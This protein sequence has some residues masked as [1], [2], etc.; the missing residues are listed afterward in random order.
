MLASRPPLGWNSWNTFGE[1]ISDPLIR[2]AVKKALGK[3]E[4]IENLTVLPLEGIPDSWE[5]LE[6]LPSLQIIELPQSAI[7]EDT[8]L[9]DPAYT[10]RLKGGSR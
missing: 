8:V 3:D 9:P 7:R 4:S 6:R 2:E 10:V 1:H 5:D